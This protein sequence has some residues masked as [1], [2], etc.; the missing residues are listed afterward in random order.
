MQ[1]PSKEEP[2]SSD[3]DWRRIYDFWFPV[4]LSGSDIVA[5]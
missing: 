3:M 5:H 2:M 4:D 1:T